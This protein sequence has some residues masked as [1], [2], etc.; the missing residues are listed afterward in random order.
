MEYLMYQKHEKTICITN[1]VKE[2]LIKFL[3]RYKERYDVIYNGV[4]LNRFSREAKLYGRINTN[5]PINIGVT[6]R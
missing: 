4:D 6:C 1:K 2:E 5:G 3:P